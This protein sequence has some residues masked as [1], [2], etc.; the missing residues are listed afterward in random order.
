MQEWCILIMTWT[1]RV[2]CENEHAYD[3]SFQKGENIIDYLK[4]NNCRECGGKLFAEH[5]SNFM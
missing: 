1:R 3:I 5:D 4:N 2:K